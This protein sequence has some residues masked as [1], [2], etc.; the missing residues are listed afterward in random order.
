MEKFGWLGRL[1]TSPRNCSA[2]VSLSLNVFTTEASIITRP[3]PLKVLRPRLPCVFTGGSANAAMFR[4]FAGSPRIGLTPVTAS[5]LS[6]A[7]KLVVLRL[8]EPLKPRRIVNGGPEAIAAMLFNCQPLSTTAFAPFAPFAMGKSQVQLKARLCLTA[9]ADNP[10][11]VVRW[12][13]FDTYCTLLLKSWE[14][15]PLASSTE[16]AKV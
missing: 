12:Y 4:Y 9:K 1:K 15:M 11:S 6:F 7:E 10:R 5:G 13:Q 3:G 16:C 2:L 14:L 8:P